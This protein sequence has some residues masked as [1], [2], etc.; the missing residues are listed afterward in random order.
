MPLELAQLVSEGRAA[1][2]TMEIQRGVVGDLASF[3]DLASAAAD[4]GT[5]ANAARLCAAARTARVPVVHC[6]AGFRSDRL[7]S[8]VNAPLVASVLRR[9]EHMLEGTAAVEL[10][11]E[12]AP[13]KTDLFSHRR[14][15]VSP[16]TGTDLD[17]T[18][19]A[20]GVSTVVATGVSLNIAIVGL[21]IEAVN[22]GYRVVVATDAVAGVP[23]EYASAVLEHTL[24]PL[25]RLATV[26]EI[27][28]CLTW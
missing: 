3:P 22:L 17:P 24:K 25:A 19:R 16:F 10:D 8:P 14:H 20:L 7:G 21:T 18:L 9:P 5:I 13:E 12:L 4:G 11:P 27:C 15:G 26:D 23:A 6:T 2:L 1:V 28:A